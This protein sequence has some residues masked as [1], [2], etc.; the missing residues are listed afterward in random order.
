VERNTRLDAN[1]LRNVA[2]DTRRAHPNVPVVFANWN[3]IYTDVGFVATYHELEKRMR[4]NTEFRD[5]IYRTTDAV[6]ANRSRMDLRR[7]VPDRDEGV[8]YVLEELAFAIAFPHLRDESR[9][10][11]VDS[12][13]TYM[14]YEGWPIY[15]KYIAGSY[16]GE[17]DDSV[18]Y[19]AMRIEDIRP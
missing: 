14:Y 16:D 7:A 17:P 12:H 18:G 9:G 1:Y 19:L 3:A 15:E 13:H 10:G 8:K 4:T 11:R 2:G 6:F 5:D